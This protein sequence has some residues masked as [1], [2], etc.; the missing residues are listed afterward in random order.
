MAPKITAG[1]ALIVLAN[2]FYSIGAFVFDFNETHVRNPRWPPH[3]RFHNGQTMT[4]GLFLSITSIY[5]L[6]RPAATKAQALDNL[7]ISALIGSFYCTAGMS[8]ILYPGTAWQDPEFAQGGEQRF[9]FSGIVVALWI[10]YW[11]EAS[12]LAKVKGS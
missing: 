8:A 10:G 7:F 4:L 2:L 5:L 1:N 11:L 6:L 12:R 3:A 9:L